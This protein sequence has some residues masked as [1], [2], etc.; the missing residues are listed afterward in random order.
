LD[1]H[2]TSLY[3][4]LSEDHGVFFGIEDFTVWNI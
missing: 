4:A 1:S 3:G 2:S